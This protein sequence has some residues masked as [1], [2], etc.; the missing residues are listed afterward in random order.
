VLVARS[1]EELALN[2]ADY[3]VIEREARVLGCVLLLPLGQSE[4]G[5]WRHLEPRLLWAPQGVVAAGN[6]AAAAACQLQLLG[7][8]AAAGPV[9]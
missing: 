8:D 4:D 1:R 9:G 2:L 6:A 7:A 3:T 5:G